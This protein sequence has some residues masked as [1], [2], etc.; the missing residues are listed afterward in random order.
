MQNAIFQVDWGF[1]GDSDDKEFACNAGYSS[2]IP[3]SGRSPGERN[4]NQLHGWRVWL[5]TVC[6]VAKSWTWLKN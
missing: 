2:S 6:G 3:G 1:P 5:A 4:G